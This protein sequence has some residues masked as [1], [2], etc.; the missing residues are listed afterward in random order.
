LH[1]LNLASDFCTRVMLLAKG[2]LHALGSPEMVLTFQNIEQAY[3]TV[4]VVRENPISR[5]PFIIPV[6]RKYL[7]KE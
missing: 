7:A 3:N 5:K 1:D 2:V 6:S 4:V